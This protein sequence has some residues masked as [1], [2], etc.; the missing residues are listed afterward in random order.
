MAEKLVSYR[1]EGSSAL[2]SQSGS[3]S[4]EAPIISFPYQPQAS[5]SQGSHCPTHNQNKL[6]LKDRFMADP[7][8]GSMK[9]AWN[10]KAQFSRSEYKT[11]KRYFAAT[12]IFALA[13]V[14]FG[15]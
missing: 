2:K 9:E 4:Y 10:H 7:L 14:L 11:L 13:V 6:T 12:F 1:T 3:A 15:A 8:F 5:Q